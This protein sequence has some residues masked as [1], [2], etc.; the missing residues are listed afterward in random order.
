MRILAVRKIATFKNNNN[1][2][3]ILLFHV[4]KMSDWGHLAF[5]ENKFRFDLLHCCL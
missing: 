1:E 4:K 2:I 3:K 5:G